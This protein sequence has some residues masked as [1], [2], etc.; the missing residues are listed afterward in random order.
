MVVKKWSSELIDA[1]DMSSAMDIFWERGWTDGLPIVIPTE[2]RVAEFLDCAGFQ[3]DEVVCRIAD[4]NRV[5]TAEKVAINGVM[6]GCLPEY[7]P[8]LVAA[9]ECLGTDEFKINHI[10]SVGSLWI[11]MIVN[12][13]IVKQ[14]GLNSGMYCFGAGVRANC[15]IA[16]GISLLLANC[17]EARTGGIQR[18]QFGYSGRF[19]NCV[20][21]NEDVEWGPP[22]NV[23][24]G[25]DS[26]TST[27]TIKEVRE[28]RTQ[29]SCNFTTSEG[30]LKTMAGA[31]PHV[32]SKDLLF[33]PPPFVEIFKKAGVTREDVQ[34]YLR[35][36]IRFSVAE[37]KRKGAWHGMDVKELAGVMPQVEQGDEQRIV[38]PYS[39]R[40]GDQEHLAGLGA[41]EALPVREPDIIPIV[42]GGDA[43]LMVLVMPGTVDWPMVTRP[44]RER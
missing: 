43:G 2:S 26:E 20:G 3:P 22:L 25:Y 8:V 16:R 31:W 29:V 15:T 7:M 13:P 14:I 30:I 24:Q 1:D 21:E 42:A 44:I 10:A 40:A 38:Y 33:I 28:G 34:Q 9:V 41:R 18:G 4:R 37:L 23:M 6:A 12:G 11:M 39:G 36:N 5:I 17:A 27:V 19:N 35:E 32:G